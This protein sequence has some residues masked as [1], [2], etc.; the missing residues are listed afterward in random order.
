MPV[1]FRFRFRGLAALAAMLVSMPA[2]AQLEITISSGVERPIP[3]AFV[4]FGWQGAG[5]QAPFDV[6]VD[7]V[8]K[9][10]ERGLVEEYESAGA[11][12]WFEAIHLS[13]GTE[14]E[15]VRRIMAGPPN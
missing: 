12:W 6:A 11:T 1:G 9:A 4:P 10:G 2:L 15:L 3:A 5:A 7:G 13:R 14:E 8:T